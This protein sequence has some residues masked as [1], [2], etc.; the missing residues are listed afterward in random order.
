MYAGTNV[1]VYVTTDGGANWRLFGAG[2]PTTAV[3]SLSIDPAGTLL[4]AA[5]NGRGIWEVKP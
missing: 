4:R 1:G 5:L 3:T 2:L